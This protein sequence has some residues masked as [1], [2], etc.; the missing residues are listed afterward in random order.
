[1]SG[2][3]RSS[4]VADVLIGAAAGAAAVWVMDRVDWFNLRHEAPEAR[5]RTQAVRPGGMDPAHV[6][7]NTAAQ[8]LGQELKPREEN[9]VGKTVHYGL[10]TISGALYGTL[11]HRVP[12]LTTGAGTLFGLGMFFLQDEGLNAMLGLSEKPRRYPWQAH[13]RGFVAHAVYGLVL[14]AA[15]KRSDHLRRR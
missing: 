15:L 5:R 8:S 4:A 7:V 2:G 10:G 1:M 12:A 14:D 3:G 6:I 13:A 9:T 11:R